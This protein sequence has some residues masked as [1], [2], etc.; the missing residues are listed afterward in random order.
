MIKNA[1]STLKL[2]QQ[3]RFCI[4]ISG[5]NIKYISIT[6]WTNPLWFHHT[7]LDTVKKPNI[8]IG[9]SLRRILNVIFC[10]IFSSPFYNSLNHM[11]ALWT[12][13][14]HNTNALKL[15][16]Y[17]A[18]T[19]NGWHLQLTKLF[20]LKKEKEDGPLYKFYEVIM[21]YGGEFMQTV[22]SM[23]DITLFAPSN[24]AWND[25]MVQNIIR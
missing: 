20:A 24:E 5:K 6:I 19:V 10:F 17:G 1:N 8:F 11:C 25:P 13:I 2:S 15:W 3:V 12:F 23:K 7:L 18:S 4:S 22:N 14:K 16:N 21:D 9:D